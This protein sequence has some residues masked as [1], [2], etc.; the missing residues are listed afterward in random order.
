MS[1]NNKQKLEKI[2]KLCYKRNTFLTLSWSYIF[3]FLTVIISN[4]LN[5]DYLA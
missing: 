5:P 3:N 2:F 4:F 1:K